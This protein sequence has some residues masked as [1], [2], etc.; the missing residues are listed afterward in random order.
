MV[1]SFLRTRLGWVLAIQ[2][3]RAEFHGPGL[4]AGGLEGLPRLRSFSRSKDAS[5]EA[6]SKHS[7]ICASLRPISAAKP[8]TAGQPLRSVSST[9]R[10]RARRM[11]SRL[12]ETLDSCS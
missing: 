1:F 4:P 3:D 9:A 2:I 11:R 12:R 8:F 5:A 6:Y 7:E 10:R